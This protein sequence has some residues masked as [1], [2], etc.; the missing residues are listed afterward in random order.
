VSE[1]KWIGSR[2][3]WHC[4]KQLQTKLGGGYH[5]STIKDPVGNLLRLHKGC[6]KQAVGE[7]YTHIKEA[8]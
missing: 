4:G 2:R 8:S 1:R 7:G 3:C 5:F 6:V